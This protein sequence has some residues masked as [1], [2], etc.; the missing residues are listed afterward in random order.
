MEKYTKLIFKGRIDEFDTWFKAMMKKYPNATLDVVL[1]D[2]G[3]E[4]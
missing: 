4:E 2:W 1:R 3:I